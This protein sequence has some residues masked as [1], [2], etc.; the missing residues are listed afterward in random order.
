MWGNN[1]GAHVNA[2]TKTEEQNRVEKMSRLLSLLPSGD[3]RMTTFERKY[4]KSSENVDC[5]EVGTV[6]VILTT[7]HD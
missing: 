4:F 2:R 3:V 1:L 6:G 5:H 7:N